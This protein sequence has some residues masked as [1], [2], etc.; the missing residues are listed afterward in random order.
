MVAVLPFWRRSPSTSQPDF[1]VLGVGDFVGGDEPGA[2]GAEGVA[3]FTLGP[4]AA[5]VFL[6]GPLA[7]VVRDAVAGDI[8]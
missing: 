6:E 7:D 3:A 4:L 5:A 8:S 2:E 1:E